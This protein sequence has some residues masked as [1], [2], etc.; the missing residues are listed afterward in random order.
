MTPDDPKRKSQAGF[1]LG[2]AP[3]PPTRRA[4][5]PPPAP[6]ARTPDATPTSR[7][8][9]RLPGSGTAAHAIYGGSERYEEKKK[10]GEGGMGLVLDSFDKTLERS[11]AFKV[12]HAQLAR[13]PAAL[14]RFL[15]E[16]RVQARL[17]HPNICPVYDMGV[18]ADGRIYFTMRKVK[19]KAL[20]DILKDLREDREAEYRL[21]HLLSIFL[22]VCEGM[23]YAHAAGIVHRDLKPDNV[24]VGE[25]GEV[26]IMDWGIAK[27]GKETAAGGEAEPE[28]AP[29]GRTQAGQL[30]GTPMYM[31]PE[32][33]DG[34]AHQVDGRS[35]VF[36][37]GV[38][39]YEMLTLELPF[40]A[41]K[42]RDIIKSILTDPPRDFQATQRGKDVPWELQAVALKCLSKDPE[43]RYQTVDE[44]RADI[45]A[46]LEGR[47]LQVATYGPLQLAA[48]WLRRHRREAILAAGLAVAA[49]GLFAG[50]VAWQRAEL[51][52]RVDALA[53]GA[54]VALDQAAGHLA[55][56]DFD[57]AR[58]AVAGAQGDLRSIRQLDPDREDAEVSIEEAA[59][60]LA[61]IDQRAAR[62]DS[63]RRA[64]ALV[65]EARE[66]LASL[67][68][69]RGRVR[70]VEDELAEAEGKLDGQE[71]WSVK[72]GVWEKR[73]SL[74]GLAREV[75][76]ADLSLRESLELAGRLD[77]ENADLAAVYA[78]YHHDLWRL[79]LEEERFPDAD[80]HAGMVERFDRG[81]DF[82]ADLDPRGAIAIDVRPPGAVARLYKFRSLAEI[83]PGGEER[84]VPVAWDA[85][86]DAPVDPTPPWRPILP[87]PSGEPLTA[88]DL[89]RVDRDLE[90]IRLEWEEGRRERALAG[91]SD[92]EVRVA[93]RPLL[94][95]HDLPV[96]V[97]IARGRAEA[98]L[99]R[100]DDALAT[101]ERLVQRGWM[102]WSVLETDPGWS[103]LA[104]ERGDAVLRLRRAS[105]GAP[106]APRAGAVVPS[107]GREVGPLGRGSWL[108][109]L[110]ASGR[111]PVRWPFRIVHADRLRAQVDLPPLE[112]VPDGFVWIAGGPSIVGS[113]GE[114]L[115]AR[116]RRRVDVPSFG[117][118]RFETTCAQY[119]AFLRAKFGR[120]RAALE[121]HSPRAGG[122]PIWPDPATPP[123]D[124]LDLPVVGVSWRDAGEY[125][126]WA[127]RAARAEATA[128]GR[129]RWPV[130][131]LPASLEWERAA[132]GADGRLHAWGDA[133]DWTFAKLGPS[134]GGQLVLEPIGRFP[135]DES[136]FGVRDLTGSVREWCADLLEDFESTSIEDIKIHRVVRGGSWVRQSPQ[137]GLAALVMAAPPDFAAT[138]IGF[139]VAFDLRDSR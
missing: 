30:L 43:R 118:A 94:R 86:R 123:A 103:A 5:P 57:A 137:C 37:L 108:L 35:D 26:L 63:L 78:E 49:I 55:K 48:K 91:L 132:R 4:P 102:D 45:E 69:G 112:D 79:A 20:S 47:T 65:V 93:G 64:A 10:L 138:D 31:S 119:A 51:A 3:A 131:R 99:G 46:F 11:V 2:A 21:T 42:L 125:C 61:E 126:E 67:R 120:D 134:R 34:E 12:A 95:R 110:E 139:R 52:R 68:E 77:P 122:K 36:T 66:K 16:A 54:R 9:A 133:F 17:E 50:Y 56:N 62:A 28:D 127:T 58:E 1:L 82:R 104:R 38:I 106:L 14:A 130:Y 114:L 27:V 6:A 87:E 115:G 88:A 107:D 109:V 90:R 89:D 8:T 15:L 100:L 60:A 23:S 105:P 40:Q 41:E 29:V 7:P 129:T 81:G 39:L 33:A 13:Q 19:G 101:L 96:E 73:R 80:F 24:M 117:L 85:A 32:L 25:F 97:A 113:D 116:E 98:S 111:T 135:R 124:W 136:P 22:K 121:A 70:L 72:A 18:G 76:A 75:D 83:A 84:L 53:E 59:R 74:S 44:L 128:A 92:L 71:P